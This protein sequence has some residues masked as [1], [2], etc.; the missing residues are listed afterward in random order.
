M[1]YRCRQW[2]T[3]SHPKY[4]WAPG[5]LRMYSYSVLYIL[6]QKL[7]HSFPAREPQYERQAE[8]REVE[9]LMDEV[10]SQWREVHDMVT[11]KSVSAKW[12]RVSTYVEHRM[13]TILHFGSQSVCTSQRD[14]LVIC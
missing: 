9:G 6:I 14:Y 13:A 8:K 11:K 4:K 12:Y 1:D 2:P 3:S 7:A 5:G 10:D